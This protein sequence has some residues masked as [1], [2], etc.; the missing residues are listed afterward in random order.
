MFGRTLGDGTDTLVR[1]LRSAHGERERKCG[2]ASELKQA[3]YRNG[4]LYKCLRKSVKLRG[5]IAR[6]A[7]R[8]LAGLKSPPS[9]DGVAGAE[10]VPFHG[11]S[12][13]R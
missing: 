5:G 13:M 7:V 4:I 12:G 2:L 10:L 6:F 8:R 11:K 3:K 1:K 9:L